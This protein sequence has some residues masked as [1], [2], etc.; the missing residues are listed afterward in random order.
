MKEI[1]TIKEQMI[2]DL[3]ELVA[4]PSITDDRETVGKALDWILQKAESLGLTARAVCDGQIGEVEIG[5][6]D[7]VL[8]VLVHSDVVHPGIEENWTSDPFTLTRKDEKLYGR[9]P[10]DD[11]GPL[12]SV[13][14]AMKDVLDEGKPLHKKIRMII[15]TK[16]ETDWEDIYRYVKEMPLPD[17]GFTP[18]GAFPVGN[19]EKGIYELDFFIPY[20]PGEEGWYLTAVESGTLDNTVPGKATARMTRFEA[21][22]PMETRALTAM[23]KGFHAGEPEKGDNAIYHLIDQ[24]EKLG[25]AD[26]SAWETLKMLR[27]H[28]SDY[29]GSGVGIKSESPFLDGEP[30]GINTISVNRLEIKGDELW[31]HVDIRYPF[32]TDPRDIK[33]I[34]E[35]ETAP[36]VTRVEETIDIPPAFV[37]SDTPFLKVLADVYQKFTGT[38]D[39]CSSGTG[40][41]YAQALPN[42][43]TFGPAFPGER[44]TCH[45]ENEYMTEDNLT[46]CYQIY[47]EVLKRF[48]F[49]SE[50]YR[51]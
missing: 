18:D 32:G 13:L 46:A 22:Q 16:E 31:F 33:A 11:K 28:F 21:G 23:G 43:V 7:E 36:L 20:R 19:I 49:S 48:A 34:L 9:G 44:L 1:E 2:A 5:E 35:K 37:K 6:G 40:G 3:A 14:Y 8:G 45:E 24:I 42:V 10:E 41:T 29:L 30:V 25:P 26:C 51:R 12:V 27:E 50:S 4:I 39:F 47:A 38:E 15:G 17:Y